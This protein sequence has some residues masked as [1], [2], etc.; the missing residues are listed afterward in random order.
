MT[1]QFALLILLLS[2]SYLISQNSKNTTTISLGLGPYT[3]ERFQGILSV[4]LSLKLYQNNT[5]YGFNIESGSQIGIKPD[6]YFTLNLLFGRDFSLLNFINFQIISGIGYYTLSESVDNIENQ[7]DTLN[8]PLKGNL[9][10]NFYR[11]TIFWR[12]KTGIG[13]GAN[14]NNKNITRNFIC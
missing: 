7:I 12:L 9:I 11:N 4:N 14:L 8:I 10:F 13:F 6:S 5:I 1:K 3:S 2:T